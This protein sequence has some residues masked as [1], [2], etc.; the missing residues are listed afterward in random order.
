ME[1]FKSH[2]N[3]AKETLRKLV[4]ELKSNGEHYIISPLRPGYLVECESN[5]YEIYRS[6]EYHS[7]PKGYSYRVLPEGFKSSSIAS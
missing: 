6:G 2:R 5:V 7:T 3:P 4:D 1:F